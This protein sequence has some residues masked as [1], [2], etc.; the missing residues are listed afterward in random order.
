M[1]YTAQQILHKNINNNNSIAMQK[2]HIKTPNQC[3]S[4]CLRHFA[5]HGQAL[6]DP[7]DDPFDDLQYP[8]TC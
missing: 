6:D 2:Y 3:L 8:S 7:F 5:A 1:A 4:C